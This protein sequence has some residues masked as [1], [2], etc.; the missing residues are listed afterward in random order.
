MAPVATSSHNEHPAQAGAGSAQPSEAADA[1]YASKGVSLS[2]QDAAATAT[3]PSKPHSLL[4]AASIP[5]ILGTVR[6][7]AADLV[8]Q[9]NGGH[10]GTAMGAAAIGVALFAS[11]I[12]NGGMRYNPKDAQW[13]NRDRFVLS[14]GHACLFQYIFL[15][16]TGYRT[17]TLGMLKRYHSRDFIGSQAHGHPEIEC[18]GSR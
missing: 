17:W 6:C 9:F 1:I 13:I 4:P 2:K 11:G 5:K 12:E 10:P 8:Q 3:T 7:L 18:E 16:L 14:A 15:H